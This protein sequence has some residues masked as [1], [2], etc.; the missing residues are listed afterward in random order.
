MIENFIIFIYCLV[1]ITTVASALIVVISRNT[2]FSA[3]ALIVMMCTLAVN[4]LLMKAEF[5]AL[6][7]L[8]VHVGK[9][10]TDATVVGRVFGCAAPMERRRARAATSVG[11]RRRS[12]AIAPRAI[13]PMTCTA[14]ATAHAVIGVTLNSTGRPKRSIT[15]R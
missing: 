11:S 4:F 7:Q 14:G 1:F 5:V 13:A 12:P 15:T 9:I 10:N 2:L 6:I 8:L 3:M